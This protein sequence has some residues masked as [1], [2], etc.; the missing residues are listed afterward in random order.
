MGVFMKRHL[1]T[2]LICILSAVPASF[3]QTPSSVAVET[4]KLD[5]VD[6]SRY[7]IPIILEPARRVEVV[8]MS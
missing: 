3:A 8:A 7:Q 4:I 5:L 2:G 6:P 1:S